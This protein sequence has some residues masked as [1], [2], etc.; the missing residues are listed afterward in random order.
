MFSGGS[1]ILENKDQTPVTN[2]GPY[3]VWVI[4]NKSSKFRF[5]TL[6]K[7]IF[8]RVAIERAPEIVPINTSSGQ[9][10]FS[11]SKVIQS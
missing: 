7:A 4:H 11:F 1:S 3:L 2:A 6:S 9:R 5:V 10:G 8:C